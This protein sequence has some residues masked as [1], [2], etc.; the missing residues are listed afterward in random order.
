M[1]LARI[2]DQ[3][4]SEAALADALSTYLGT[5]RC[6]SPPMSLG[7]S[8]ESDAVSLGVTVPAIGI[9]LARQKEL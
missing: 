7:I 8:S 1:L 4:L 2:A 3:A 6:P 9:R 5:Y